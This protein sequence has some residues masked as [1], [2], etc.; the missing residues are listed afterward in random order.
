MIDYI[1]QDQVAEILFNHKPA[2]TITNEFL[3]G[4]FAA[5]Q[6]AEADDQV[7]AILIASALPKRFC[8]GL[9]L[10]DFLNNSATAAHDVVEKLY[11]RLVDLQFSMSKPTIAAISGAVRGGGMTIAISC[12]MII[13]DAQSNFGYPE[14]DIGLLPAIHYNNL[15]RIVGRY[16]AFDLLFTG[17]VFSAEEALS[18]GLI[19]RIAPAGTLL[20]EARKLAHVLALKSPQLMRKGKS[21]FNQAIDTGYRQGVATAVNL[22]GT[23]VSMDDCREGLSAF[24]EKRKPV[25]KGN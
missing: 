14:I 15:P 19:S 20:D 7:R 6:R 17:R 8:A 25:W 5:L 3:D 9:N 11:A 4:L 23:V 21:G 1:V 16:R 24:V 2:N 12:D 18:L 13:A 22:I 10:A